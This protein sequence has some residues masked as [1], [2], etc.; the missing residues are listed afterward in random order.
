MSPETREK[1]VAKLG[2]MRK[3]L[4]YPEHW[5]DY[6]ALTVT[7]GDMLGNAE[8]ASRVRDAARDGQDRQA[9]RSRRVGDKPADGQRLLR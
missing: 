4:G 7:R 9:G 5:R 3:K 2:L 8:R 6:G 1:A